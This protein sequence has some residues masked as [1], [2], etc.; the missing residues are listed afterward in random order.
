[1]IILCLEKRGASICNALKDRIELRTTEKVED[2][3]LKELILI[4]ENEKLE[5]KSTLRYDLRQNIVNKNLEYVIA[6]TVSAFLNSE[7]GIL[8]IGVDDDGNA[9]GLKKDIETFSKKDIDGFELHLRNIIKKHLGSNFE[10][11]LKVS[12]PIIDEKI[13]CKVKILKSGKP[14]FANFEGKD[15]FYVRNGN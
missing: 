13:I 11:H 12:F 1:M 8:I 6:K 4:G 2:T 5:M 14:V 7:G 15:S 9:L 10:K 3:E